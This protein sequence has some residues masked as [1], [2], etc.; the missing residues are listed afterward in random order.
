MGTY[1]VIIYLRDMHC[2]CKLFAKVFGVC[3]HG[4]H[5]KASKHIVHH[6]KKHVVSPK[7]EKGNELPIDHLRHVPHKDLKNNTV[8]FRTCS[9]G[10]KDH[11]HCIPYRS[12]SE[13]ETDV[14]N[15]NKRIKEVEAKLTGFKG[16]SETS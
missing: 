10:R 6:H 1:C 14:K 2:I 15:F 13:A 8:L 5:K 16:S 7:L 11:P 3:C 4:C 12:K 9:T